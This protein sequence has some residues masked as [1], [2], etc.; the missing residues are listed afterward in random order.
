MVSKIFTVGLVFLFLIPLVTA[1]D[2]WYNLTN[3][4]D[5]DQL[6]GI[7][8]VSNVYTKGVF[9]IMIYIGWF[10]LLL[11]VFADLEPKKAF[12]G[13]SFLT[14]LVGIVMLPL[15]II[16]PWLIL[17]AMVAA[18]ASLISLFW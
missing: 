16:N 11:F 10:L 14:A 5:E 18:V 6:V 9:G 8:E 12:A 15:N 4:T 1:L 17:V 3:F 7:F 2:P 13:A